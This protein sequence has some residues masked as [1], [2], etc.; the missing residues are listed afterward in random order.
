M[1]QIIVKSEFETL[2]EKSTLQKCSHI[3]Y[4]QAANSVRLQIKM[5]DV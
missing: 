1:T 3:A 5:A 2:I 4:K